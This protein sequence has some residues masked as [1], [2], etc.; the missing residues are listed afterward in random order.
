M[1]SSSNHI[2]T[3][4][5]PEAETL[6]VEALGAELAGVERCVPDEVADASVRFDGCLLICAG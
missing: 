5:A 4:N 2:L 3:L 6:V 1:Q